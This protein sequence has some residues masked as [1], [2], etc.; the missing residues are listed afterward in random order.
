MF[1]AVFSVAKFLLVI[2]LLSFGELFLFGCV[3]LNSFGGKSKA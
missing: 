1:D 3:R 2:L